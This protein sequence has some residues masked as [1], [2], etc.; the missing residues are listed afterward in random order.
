MDYSSQSLALSRSNEFCWL[1]ILCTRDM[2]VGNRKNGAFQFISVISPFPARSS[3][4]AYQKFVG[5]QTFMDWLAQ[6]VS[7]LC[8][9]CPIHK[10]PGHCL[11]L[12]MTSCLDAH[13]QT[14]QT[15]KPM[16]QPKHRNI[17]QQFAVP[18]QPQRGLVRPKDFQ[19][20]CLK[21]Q[22]S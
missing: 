1:G 4:Q 11:V 2:N 6:E 15:V 16:T 14:D 19:I 17:H 18:V 21:V 3:P 22:S 20:V 13:N 7:V 8:W 9:G 12:Q 5:K 10:Q